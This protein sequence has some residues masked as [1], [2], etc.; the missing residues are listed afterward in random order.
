M[1]K[2][3][4]PAIACFLCLFVATDMVQAQRGFGRSDRGGDRGG[5]RGSD[6]GS[7]D[8]GRSWGGGSSRG[9]RP[10][11][12]PS[13]VGGRIAG[14]FDRNRDGYIDKGELDRMPSSWKERF[15]AGGIDTRRGI[16]VADFGKKA[17]EAIKQR[18]EQRR[19]E[20]EGSSRDRDRRDYGRTDGSSKTSTGGTVFKQSERRKFLDQLP[21][22]YK[23]GDSD[24]DGQ[25]ALYEWA[26]WK[27]SDMFAFFEL[28]ANQDGFLTPRE[29][30]GEKS[31]ADRGIVAKRGRLAVSGSN[32]GSRVRSVNSPNARSKSGSKRTAE[33]KSRDQRRATYYFSA[34]DRDRDGT[35][36]TE[37]WQRSRTVR[38]TFEKA[39]IAV[40]P[41]SEKEFASSYQKAVEKTGGSSNGSDR[42]RSWG[43]RGNTS[44]RSQWGG[45]RGGSSSSRGSWGDR[46]SSRGGSSRDRGSRDR[47]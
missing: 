15:N 37:E 36:S 10:D 35:I 11:F 7:R 24:G 12:D 32:G 9:G 14:Y 44:S 34:L 16:S 13:Q 39:G 22:E 31:E 23:E 3:R 43:D 20:S 29:L 17:G 26:A 45:D 47:R 28:D 6:R 18:I 46:G 4:L 30:E 19:S 42:S 2:L 33:E 1:R 40:K 38:G 25:V 21:E 5:D 8:R 27:R 41:M